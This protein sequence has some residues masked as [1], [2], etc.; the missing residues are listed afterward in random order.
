MARFRQIERVLSCGV[1]GYHIVPF[2]N[3]FLVNKNVQ[4][5]KIILTNMFLILCINICFSFITT[6][7]T[8]S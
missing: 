6:H 4:N 1:R 8:F 5:I 3:F 2:Y 7:S